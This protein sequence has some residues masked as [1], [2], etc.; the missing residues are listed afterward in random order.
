VLTNALFPV[1]LWGYKLIIPTCIPN[2]IIIVAFTSNVRRCI[3]IIIK[4][5]VSFAVHRVG[6][7]LRKYLKFHIMIYGP[8]GTT[9]FIKFMAVLQ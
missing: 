2:I 9:E 1:K 8:L 5:G 6:I 7:H 3:Q 4:L